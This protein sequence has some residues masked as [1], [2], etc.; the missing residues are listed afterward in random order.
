MGTIL[1]APVRIGIT[2]TV[3][4]HNFLVLWQ[5]PR[6]CLS[7]RFLWF[8]LCSPLRRKSQLFSK[9][10]FFFYSFFF[11]V[12]FSFCFVFCFCFFFGGG[13]VLFFFV[14]FFC[15]CCWLSRGLVFWPGLDDLFECQNPR[16]FLILSSMTD[17]GLGIYQIAVCYY[18]FLS[19]IFFYF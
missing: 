2:V 19:F 12:F 16:K 1:S 11:L 8:S 13:G 7:F 15:C 10:S 14:V 4:F 5:S 3:I 9:F 6:T 18:N 17:S